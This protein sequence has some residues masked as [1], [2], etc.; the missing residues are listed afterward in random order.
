MSSVAATSTPVRSAASR[1][2]RVL[3]FVVLIL[4]AAVALALIAGSRP[5]A[6]AL[7]PEDPGAEGS[8]A[9]VEVLRAH[10]VDVTVVR[11]ADRLPR[12][13]G[14][15]TLVLGNPQFF[16]SVAAEH[17]RAAAGGYSRVVMVMP[18]SAAV[19][20]LG[21]P[22]Q[23]LS[24]GSN[25]P[26]PAR[27]TGPGVAAGDTI[28]PASPRL[29]PRA[30]ASGCFPYAVP[31]G[32]TEGS[33]GY[34]MVTIPGTGAKP[35]VVVAGLQSVMSNS[36]ILDADNAGV[37]VRLLGSAPRLVWYQPDVTDTDPAA[38]SVDPWPAW[39]WPAVWVLGLAFVLFAV[40]VGR[41]F[42]RLVPE[43]LPVVVKAS[44]TTES[45]ARLY[46]RTR[47]Y[48]RAAAIL[49]QG[50]THRLRQRLGAGAPHSDP[51]ADPALVALVASATGLP[52]IV[53]AQRLI[54]PPPASDDA[55]ITLSQDLAD[56]EEKATRT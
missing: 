5:P 20:S 38:D 25:T 48:A 6:I 31:S 56:L 15:A 1:T 42:G 8:M 2:R 43:P 12:P 52:E 41:R 28:A 18:T 14:A 30:G 26:V 17:F 44:E 13:G 22:V 3:V 51:V 23:V 55:L 32:V 21:Y 34:A 40:A 7:D 37:A 16:G 11:S 33:S 19:G 4:A 45:R 39:R 24:G 27:C 49:R 53:V 36:R 46:Q 10:G 35:E 54:G 9:L 47:D 29:V 50:S